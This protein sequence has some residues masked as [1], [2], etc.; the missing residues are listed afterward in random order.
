M[1]SLKGSPSLPLLSRPLAPGF[2]A[3][4]ENRAGK[5]SHPTTAKDFFVRPGAAEEGREDSIAE[6]V[7]RPTQGGDNAWRKKPSRQARK[8]LSAS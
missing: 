4:T 1:L 6:Y 3:V 8:R 7:E 5:P 2:R